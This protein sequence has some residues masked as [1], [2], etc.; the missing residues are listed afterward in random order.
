M[1]TSY[2][3]EYFD[4]KNTYDCDFHNT[5]KTVIA[6]FLKT[7]CLT[8]WTEEEYWI[9]KN[10]C[11]KVIVR[12]D[13]LNLQWAITVMDIGEQDMPFPWDRFDQWLRVKSFDAFWNNYRR[14]VKK[15]KVTPMSGQF[16]GK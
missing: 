8:G 4:K 5:S 13:D 16:R 1:Q 7:P 15:I 11:Y 2:D 3:S 12:I 9:G 10:N 6:N 14:T